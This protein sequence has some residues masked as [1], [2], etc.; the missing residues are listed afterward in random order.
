MTSGGKGIIAKI[1]EKSAEI[2][3]AAAAHREPARP[4][5]T[6]QPQPERPQG[7]RKGQAPLFH[8]LE[9]KRTEDDHNQRNRTGINQQDKIRYTSPG[10]EIEEP[11][12]THGI[13]PVP[14]LLLYEGI[15]FCCCHIIA[16]STPIA[17]ILSRS[18]ERM[19]DS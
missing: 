17:A 15:V 8:D 16:L 9:Y 1:C 11:H 13:A 4:L 10:I 6:K 18:Q 14:I 5:I 2:F 7:G 19:N 3:H 12:R